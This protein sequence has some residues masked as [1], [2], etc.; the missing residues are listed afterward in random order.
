VQEKQN[1]SEEEGVA[2]DGKLHEVTNVAWYGDL[3]KASQTF[4]QV[5]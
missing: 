5:P 4:E 1:G 2:S 3:G